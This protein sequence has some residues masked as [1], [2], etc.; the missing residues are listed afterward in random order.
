MGSDGGVR[1]VALDSII[2]SISLMELLGNMQTL[3]SR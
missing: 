3:K 2:P 1:E